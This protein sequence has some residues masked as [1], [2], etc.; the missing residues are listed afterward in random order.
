[1]IHK[2]ISV[3]EIDILDCRIAFQAP[4]KDSKKWVAKTKYWILTPNR[5]PFSDLEKMDVPH[6]VRFS[7]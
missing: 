6:L 4:R 5:P 7:Q 1:M 3:A 2:N